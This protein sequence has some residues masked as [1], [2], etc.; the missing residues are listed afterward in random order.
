MAEKKKT[1]TKRTAADKSAVKPA[2]V[3]KET[4]VEK[5]PEQ[6]SRWDIWSVFWGVI[7]VTIGVLLLL[8]N[9]GVLAVDWSNVW[10]LWP[11]FIVVTGFSILATTHWIWRLLS[12]VVVLGALAGVLWFATGN[13]EESDNA[14]RT[15]QTSVQVEDGVRQVDVELSAGASRIEVDSHEGGNLA[16]V[17]LESNGLEIDKRESRDGD[18]QRV[19]LSADRDRSWWLMPDKNT[20]NVSV[21]ERLPL[22]FTVDAGASSIDMDLSNTMLR[23]L[24]VDSG[25]SSLDIKLGSKEAK[26]SVKIDSGASSIKLRLPKNSGV[27]L[28]LDGGLNSKNLADLK[29]VSEDEYRTDNYDSA[30]KTIDITADAGVASITIERY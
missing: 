14:A 8:S 24:K 3:T 5:Q 9:L 18:T 2:Q 20:W 15:Q 28:K 17:K 1:T 12:V 13:Y 27:S 25:A 30:V 7:L 4:A 11:L 22:S 6:K 23:N 29:E 19:E 26:Q 16:D 10:R 21:T